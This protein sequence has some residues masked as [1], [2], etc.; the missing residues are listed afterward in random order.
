MIEYI[1]AWRKIYSKTVAKNFT[2]D[3][4]NLIFLDSPGESMVRPITLI[5][6]C[7]FALSACSDAKTASEISAAYVPTGK[8][9]RMSCRQLRSELRSARR[10][11]DD[12]KDR[13]EKSYR[14]DKAAE[15]VGW[16]LFAPA[17]LMMD[18]NSD[19]QKAFGEAKGKVLAIEDTMDGKG[20]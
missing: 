19:E 16:I 14:E 3:S 6:L 11:Q 4:F 7:L 8:Y 9:E 12:M 5:T 10:E 15:A 17:L 18:G 20:C 2:S 1:L 13:I